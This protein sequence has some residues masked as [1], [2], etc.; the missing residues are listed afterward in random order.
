MVAASAS[1]ER[2]LVGRD[3]ELAM[4]EAA[5]GQGR[6]GALLEGEP[7]IGKT[8]LWIAGTEMARDRGACV[9]ES[10]PGEAER[11]LS[12]SALDDLLSN[13]LDEVL[14]HIPSPRRRALEVALL[15]TDDPNAS[16]DPARGIDGRPRGR[17][18]ART[19]SPR[20][21]GDRRRAVVGSG[22]P[23]AS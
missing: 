18:A 20:R 23:P 9:L 17:A 12:F 11:R 5:L 22:G 8:A 6:R 15:R 3:D 4:V 7:G 10:R 16:P 13:E 1:I 19:R 2:S 21:V 14:P